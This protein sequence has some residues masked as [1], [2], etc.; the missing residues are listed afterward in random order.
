MVWRRGNDK[1]A[2]IGYENRQISPK[3]LTRASRNA[4]LVLYFSSSI[5]MASTPHERP[6]FSPFKTSLSSS[7][8]GAVS[9]ISKTIS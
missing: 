7:R 8:D 2:S 6:L 3:N 1:Y 4:G 5:G 9:S